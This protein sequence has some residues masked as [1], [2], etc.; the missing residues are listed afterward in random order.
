MVLVSTK[1]MSLS[2]FEKAR[3]PQRG[4]DFSSFGGIYPT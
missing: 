2:A 3:E 1:Y 4:T